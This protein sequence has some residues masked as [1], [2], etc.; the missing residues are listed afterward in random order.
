MTFLAALRASA[1]TVGVAALA[2]P[3]VLLL[4]FHTWL[5]IGAIV[6]IWSFLCVLQ[7]RLFNAMARA[8]GL[9]ILFAAITAGLPQLLVSATVGGAV[10]LSST[11]KEARL[12]STRYAPAAAS[13]RRLPRDAG[14]KKRPTKTERTETR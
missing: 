3:L 8:S 6:L 11:H 10:F 4:G 9:P 2:V 12:S 14:A 5:G 13:D 7:W 1:Y